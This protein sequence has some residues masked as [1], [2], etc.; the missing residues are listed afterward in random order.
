MRLIQRIRD[1]AMAGTRR[2]TGRTGH[3][4]PRIA[5]VSPK[6]PLYRRRGGIF[7]QSLRYM[8]LTFPTLA[9]LVPPELDA[10][11]RCYDEGIDELPASIDADLVGL[12]VLTG[13]APRAYEL[14]ARYRAAGRTVVLGGPH[15]TLAPDEAQAHADAIVVG[16]AEDTW[17][18]LLRDFAAGRLQPRYVQGPDL[19]L[20]AR[21]LPRRSVLPR[22]KYLT[23]HVFE[24]TRSCRHGCEFCVAPSAW[25]RKQL[26]KPVAAIVDDMRR[27]GT[28]RAIFVDL[29]LISDRDYA[30][31]LFTALKPLGIQWYGLSTTR[32]CDDL[33]LLDLAAE[34]GCRGLLMGLES[35]VPENLRGLRKGFNRPAE[36]GRIVGLLHERNISL[37]GCFVFGLDNDTPEVFARTAELAVDVGIDLPRFAIATPFPGTPLY[38]RL[39]RE[40]RIIDWNWEHYDGQHVVFQP[41]RMSVGELEQGLLRA[42]QQAYSWP[43]IARRLRKTAAPWY[44]AGLTN[45]GYR[46]YAFGLDRFYNC[47]WWFDMPAEA[48]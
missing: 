43:G 14:A 28:R 29:N 24:A 47:D 32:L 5:L 6:G 3:A 30:R 21:P 22:R 41:A 9:A 37:Q 40:N 23:R 11:I 13:T 36:Y 31:E 18:Q 48:R 8:P 34:S 10:S 7:R 38:H 44:V 46:H 2:G 1:G 27:L 33:P 35:I 45:L 15:I 42:W 25:G 12:T 19:D 16:Y 4:G 26:Q 17:P 39:R 20:A